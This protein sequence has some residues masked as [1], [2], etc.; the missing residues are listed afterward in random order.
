M[1]DALTALEKVSAGVSELAEFISQIRGKTVTGTLTKTTVA[2]TIRD[3]AL[4]Y[5]ESVRADLGAVKQRAGLVDEIDWAMETLLS[6]TSGPR[7][8]SAYLGT[9]AEVRPYLVE[10]VISLMK[11]RG[12]PKL[13][14]S[15]IEKGIYDTLARM[16]PATSASY[17][18]VLRDIS[19]GKRISWRGPATE[20]R[21]VLRE[22]IDHLAPD[23]QVIAA[24][25]FKFEKDKDGND[26]TQPTQKQKVRF[27]LKARRSSS[28]AV[29]VA[30]TSLETFENGI[31]TLARETYNRGSVSTHTA[32][33]ADE[34]RN[35]KGYVDALLAE[36]LKVPA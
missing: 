22:V 20:L 21:E 27:I 1:A 31:A 10:G 19:D 18:Q 33:N 25:N 14:L 2:P 32:T 15:K 17:E 24:P 29:T 8:K 5:F 36:L 35:L 30:E 13:V 11:A 7:E 12:T 6:L 3:I 23:D 28:A 34:L 16:L 4:T 26:R 9:L